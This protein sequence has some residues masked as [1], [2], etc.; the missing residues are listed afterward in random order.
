MKKTIK[1]LFTFIF[2]FNILTITANAMELP[3]YLLDAGC[4]AI[5]GDPNASDS[6][7]HLLQEVFTV[8]KFLAP[9]MVLA[10]SAIDFIKAT[11]SQDKDILQKAIKNSIIRLIVGL[12]VMVLPTLINFVFELIG[13]YG[14]CGV[15]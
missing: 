5:L 2:L 13:W 8:I 12:L 3:V 4:D 11:A 15:K 10:F 7:A 9:V 6:V 14:T 1:Y